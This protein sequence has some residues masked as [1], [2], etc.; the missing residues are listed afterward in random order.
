MNK[1]KAASRRAVLL[2]IFVL[3]LVAA[4]IILP[5]NFSQAGNSSKKG[6]WR[7]ESH[8]P[9]YDN[10]DIRTDKSDEAGQFF[11]ASRQSA[12]LTENLVTDHRKGFV[13]GEE[14]L[15]ATVPTL[16]IEY[17]E[18]IRIPEVIAPD[19][20][21]GTASLTGPSSGVKNSEILRNFIRQNNLLI[22]VGDVQANQLKATQDYTNPNGDLS[23]AMLEQRINEIPVFRGEIKAGFNK[24]GEMFRVINNLAPGLNYDSLSADFGSP[25]DAVKAAFTK[26]SRPMTADDT[27]RNEA[28][29]NDLK[30]VFGSGDWATTAEKMYFPTEPGVAVPAWR[31]LIWQPVNAYYVIVDAKTGTM[32]WRKNITNDQAQSAT[33]SVYTQPAAMV[34]VGAN[35]APMSPGPVDPTLGQ[36]GVIGTRVNMTLVGNEPPYAFNS[37]GWIT[38]GANGGNGFTDGNNVEAGDDLGGTNGVDAPVAGVTR[39]FSNAWNPP[40]GSPPPGDAVTTT[41]A[42]DGAVIQMFY[43]M[44]RYHDEMYL[45]GFN[46]QSFNFQNDN[47]GRGGAAADR[48]S[49]EGQDSSGTNNA[50]FSTP[51]DGGRGR[52]QMYVWTGPSPQRDGTGDAEVIFHEVTHGTSNRLHGNASGLSTNM[53]GAMGE[54]WS[55]FYGHVLLSRPSEPLDSVNVTGGYALLNGFGVVGTQNYYYGIRRFPKAR[56]SFTGGPNNRP[57][58]PMTFA[59]IDS[60]QINVTNGAYPAMAGP[61]ISTSADQVHAAGEIWSS[62]LWEVRCQ[63]VARL[64]WAV[65]NRKALQLV[66]DGM[67]LAPLGPTFL[68]ERDAIITAAANSALGPEASADVADVREGFRI[69]GMGFSA[70]IQVAGSGG[71]TARVTEAFDVPNALIVDPFSVSDSTGDNDGFPEPGENVLL[72]VPIRN[73]SGSTINNVV[74]SV[75]GGGSANYGNIADGQTVTRQI[76]YT[77]PAGAVCGSMHQV[78]LTG[79]SAVGAL[80]PQNKSFRLGAPVGGAPVSF[81]SST[82]LVIPGTG[83][84]PGVSAP[85][86]TTIN[87]SGLTGN[88]NIKLELTGLTHTFPGDLDVLLVGPGG[89]KFIPLSDAGGTTDLVAANVVLNDLATVQITSTADTNLN[90]EFKPVDV[91]SGDT[92]DAPAPA[93]PYTSPIPVGAATF[94]STFGTSGAAMNGT[95]TL[96]V[97]DDASIDSGTMAGWKL[98]FEAN[99]YNCSIGPPLTNSDARADFD[100][101]GKTDLSVFRPSEGNWYLNRSTAGFTVVHWGLGSDTLVPGDYDGDDKTDTAVYRPS[102]TLGVPDFFVLR[103]SNST[104]FGIE[105]GLVGDVPIPGDYTGGDLDDFA[106]YRQS[107]GYWYTY[108]NPTPPVTLG[109]EGSIVTITFVGTTGTPVSGDFDGDDISDITMFNAGVWTIRKSTG[110]T[111]TVNWGQAGDKLV[112]ADYDGDGKD[113]EAVFRNGS[114]LI[115]G[116]LGTDTTVNWG[117]GTDVPVPGD[118][119]GDGKDDVA[120]YRNGIWYVNGSTSGIVI[121]NFGLGSDS[122]V[123]RTYQQP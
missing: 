72:S 14:E 42:R 21:R 96:Y 3:G 77:V 49:A 78:T 83:T 104:V 67:K 22:G 34:N 65:G 90:G 92:F 114:W 15:R 47:F 95:W 16:K 37:L 50:N 82:A 51:A 35:P 9:G 91:T 121:S 87:V 71:G 8:E 85:Y 73:T 30:V 48:V 80:N 105:F 61:H 107:T 10:Y 17:N 118:Y 97:R 113:D 103:S 79:T 1:T 57:H 36:Q 41:V 75:T 94:A 27:T 110:G 102:N 58:N 74:G 31:V 5:Y 28:V 98:T 53:A 33:Y 45:L 18:D 38:D 122:A 26:V 63:M 68:Q 112:P 29:S 7:T 116:S 93:G 54:G 101:D 40:P 123:A 70:S 69:R 46:E 56:L 62:A 39:V 24:R 120:V 115:H 99:D 117:L 88:K 108:A 81:T 19:I 89:Q 13:R 100:G 52:M 11:A 111:A 60:T 86:G 4:L 32:L 20:D 109:P 23:Y 2:S 119:D 6:G 25:A 12:G 59:D 76:A 44:N 64:G 106:V 66:T 43:N 84:G 55:D